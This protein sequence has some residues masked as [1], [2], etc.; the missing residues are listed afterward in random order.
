MA[1]IP[2]AVSQAEAAVHLPSVLVVDDQPQICE[3]FSLVAGKGY[4]CRESFS[5]ADALQVLSEHDLDIIVSDVRMPGMNGIELLERAR[6]IRPNSARILI[7]G[8]SDTEA[9]IAGVNEG[10]I[11]FF[12]NKPFE[13]SALQAV[14]QQAAEYSR[15]MHERTRLIEEL[16]SLNRE[17]DHL[18]RERTSELGERTKALELALETISKIANTDPLTQLANRRHMEETLTKESARCQ[19][20]GTNIGVILG[21]I[22]HFKRVND[23]FGHAIGDGVL[24]AVANTFR[25]L[26]RPYDLAVRYGG[27]EIV[28]LMPD[29]DLE[30]LSRAAERI[31]IKL[32]EIA[33]PDGPSKVTASFGI[34]IMK[35]GES[36]DEIMKA[37]DAAL[38]RAKN[39]GRD[40]VVYMGERAPSAGAI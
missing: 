13:K 23:T 12:L 18:V 19:R 38:Y 33:I 32:H 14:L 36:S 10:H 16:T 6:L 24:V 8:Y 4:A 11:L 31:R 5:G 1:T 25:E 9:I 17:L 37:V 26:I 22:D 27:E 28:V 2:A 39:E 34:G 30:S 7:S 15:L 21:D 29:I 20:S 40:R 3:L 35:P